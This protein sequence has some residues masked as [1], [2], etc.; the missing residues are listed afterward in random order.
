MHCLTESLF[1]ECHLSCSSHWTTT[2]KVGGKLLTR[3]INGCPTA[4]EHDRWHDILD[5][6]HIAGMLKSGD[7]E[8]TY[9][10]IA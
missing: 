7:L 4:L 9:C 10:E 1:L 6:L 8:T 3:Y 2:P 5:D